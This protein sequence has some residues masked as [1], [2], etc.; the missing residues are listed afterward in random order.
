MPRPPP[1]H[2]GF[3]RV[4]WRSGVMHGPSVKSSRRPRAVPH[5]TR[6]ASVPADVAIL[7]ESLV[8]RYGETVALDGVSF[9]VP[10]GIVCGIL[11]PNGAGKT[12]AVR[13]LTTLSTTDS[14]SALVA[15]IDVRQDPIA[16]RRLL[17]LAAQD[18]I[19]DS[20]LTGRENLVMIG[21]LHHLG[22]RTAKARADE[23]PPTSP[24]RRRVGAWRRPAPAGCAG[25]STWRRPWWP[26]RDP[27]PRRAHDRSRP[28]RAR[29]AV[30]GPGDAGGRGGDDPPHGPVPRRGRPP[31]GRHRG[32]RP[33]PR[34]RARRRPRAEEP[35]R[36]G[37][38]LR[39]GRQPLAD[40]DRRRPSASSWRSRSA[41]TSPRRGA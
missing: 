1:G 33:R 35:G 15:G 40:R 19:V 27:V 3:H 36:R 4:G 18:A 5:D 26:P 7:A 32:D 28:P 23:L 17:G 41:P 12:T 6:G 14:G 30:G 25:A 24:S 21:E 39:H 13:V 31:G 37:T 29:R 8:K 9:D 16:V 10:R 2:E 22:R 11:G 20:L 38:A 34:H